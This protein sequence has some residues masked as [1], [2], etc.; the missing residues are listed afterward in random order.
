MIKDDL[1]NEDIPIRDTVRR[2]FKRTKTVKTDTNI[3]F[4]NSTCELV[5]KAVRKNIQKTPTT[6]RARSWSAEST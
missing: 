5:A 1:F 4:K 3:A 2:F 6:R